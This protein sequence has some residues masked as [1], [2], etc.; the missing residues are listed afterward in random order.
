MRLQ[1]ILIFAMLFNAL[2]I[3]R[4]GSAEERPTKEEPFA[5]IPDTISPEA[6]KYLESLSNPSTLPAWPA[7]DD[8]PGWKRLWEAGEVAS[9]PKVDATLKRYEPVVQ[10]L[11]LS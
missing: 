5:P 1:A 10:S 9:A 8:L 2:L 7:S 4:I 6:R 11:I 3:C